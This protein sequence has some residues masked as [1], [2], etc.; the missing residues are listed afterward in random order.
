MQLKGQSQPDYL[1]QL[2]AIQEKFLVA[3][4]LEICNRL[5]SM[6]SKKW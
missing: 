5:K 1:D 3:N 6:M 2:P 4:A